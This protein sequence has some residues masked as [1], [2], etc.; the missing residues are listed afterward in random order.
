MLPKNC[1]EKLWLIAIAVYN[2]KFIILSVVNSDLLN[3][4]IF[5]NENYPIVV[6]SFYLNYRV[7]L[8][9]LI[10]NIRLIWRGHHCPCRTAILWFMLDT[11]N[12]FAGKGVIA[13]VLEFCDGRLALVASLYSW[14]RLVDHELL[15]TM[16]RKSWVK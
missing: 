9:V 2:L 4:H 8:F 10:E 1:T 13:M 3:G 6:N 16:L 11:C 14:H 15:L 5:Y 7:G 12:L